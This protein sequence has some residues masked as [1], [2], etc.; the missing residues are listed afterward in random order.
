MISYDQAVAELV[1]AIQK[2]ESITAFQKVKEKL[3][4]DAELEHLV[5]DMKGFQQDAVLFNRIDK[6]KASEQAGQEADHMQE[7]LESLPIVQDYRDKMQDAS[8]LIQ[9]VTKTLEEKINED[10]TDGK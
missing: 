1:D 5:H 8:D 7:N 6:Q 9:Y 2:H 10:L 4:D 3:E